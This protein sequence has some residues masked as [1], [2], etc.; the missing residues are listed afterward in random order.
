MM[1]FRL[2]N[3]TFSN[4]IT[5]LQ[6]GFVVG[7]LLI[8]SSFKD[9][10][11]VHILKMWSECVFTNPNTWLKIAAIAC[12]Y[13]EGKRGGR[14]AIAAFGDAFLFFLFPNVNARCSSRR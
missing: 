6:Y 4:D 7:L 14:G 13:Y 2:L 3:I 5:C 8:Q 1:A 11:L 12:L 10:S 9:D